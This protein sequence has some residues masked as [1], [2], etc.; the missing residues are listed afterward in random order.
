MKKYLLLF[1][2]LGFLIHLP[3][4]VT[5]P[6]YHRA[7][8]DLHNKNPLKILR[9]G[10][11]AD[12][13]TVYPG[14]YLINDFSEREIQL[15]RQADFQVEILIEDVV[16]F[17][18]SQGS[19]TLE[20]RNTEEC[21]VSRITDY[22]VPENFSLGG[23][24]GFFTYQEMLEELDAMHAKYPELITERA[25]IGNH[26]TTGGNRI[27]WLKISDNPEVEEP[28]PEVL[29]TALHHAREPNSL[30]QLVFYMWY[31]LENYE[32]NEEIRYLLNNTALYFIPCVNPDGYLFNQ[33][34]EPNG[35]GLW[36]KNRRALEGGFVGVD[37]NRN[38]GFQWGYDNAGSSPNP[39]SDV[40][41]GTAPFSEVETRAVRDFC[42]AHNFRVALNCHTYGKLLVYP[43]GY[44]DTPTSDADIFTNWA[45][46]Y[47]LQNNYLAGTGSE[48]VGYTVNGDADDWM[49][50]AV[51][52]IS[53][54]PEVGRGGQ[55]GGFW[56]SPDQIIPN[57]KAS[58]WMNLAGVRVLHRFGIAKD[59]G[60]STLSLTDPTLAFSL[61]RYGLESGPLHVQLKSLSSAIEVDGTSKTF[62]S[63]SLYEETQDKFN[64]SLIDELPEGT[65]VTFELSV[66]NGSF[67]VR[68]TI[69]KLIRFNQP[70][71]NDPLTSVSNW[72]LDG[73]WGI[74]S[75]EFVSAPSSMTDSPLGNYG[76]D[77]SNILETKD[78]ITAPAF[79]TAYLNFWARWVT[80]SDFD[81]VQ[82]QI[83]V[84]DGEFQPLCG[85]YSELGTSNQ[86]EGEPLY[87]GAQ[88]DWVHEN[89][90]LQDYLTP[91]D[92]FKLRFELVS[93]R[94]ITADGFY[95]DDL[96]VFFFEGDNITS[97]EVQEKDFARWINVF[98]NPTRDQLN[99]KWP[100]TFAA[101]GP[102]QLF[103]YDNLGRTVR[104]I[105]EVPAMQNTYLLKLGALSPGAYWG[106]LRN[107]QGEHYSFQFFHQKSD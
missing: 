6:L 93:D 69:E 89:I 52:I 85:K 106:Q 50:G 40:Y 94:F 56:P 82:V 5:Q 88:L 78:Y 31:L 41:R 90:P 80:E 34:I 22:Q 98:P 63:L 57:C 26:M 96:E 79:N 66:D 9:L 61:K 23:M 68:D 21:F 91:G 65:A 51:D 15:L 72:Q 24:G 97:V 11:E 48:T 27:Y 49:Y 53:M 20:E 1:V 16:S 101:A 100:T 7:K 83:A 43:W 29:Y 75:S 18:Q 19:T 99:I 12:H 59:I 102:L 10:I 77:A 70:V 25:R 64:W 32:T 84:N 71:F 38:Y 42:Q 105:R 33:A 17:Y 67:V 36:R 76:N 13:G 73:N 47:T 35:G 74:S 3:A 55:G 44:L 37:L 92:R 86:R 30:S 104:Q 14:K 81:F 87:D 2:L 60:P 95:F 39:Q 28:E 103:I 54:T 107:A 4:Q 46:L 45:E 58:M 62:T 8:V